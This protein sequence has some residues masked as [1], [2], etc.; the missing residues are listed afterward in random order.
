M[1]LNGR[2]SAGSRSQTAL[3]ADAF[4]CANGVTEIAE[5]S[6]V[7]EPRDGDEFVRF[8]RGAMLGTVISVLFYAAVVFAY[9]ALASIVA[10][11]AVL[12]S[13]AEHLETGV[14]ITELGS[15]SVR[16]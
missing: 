3:G 2:L 15:N 9:V 6:R 10:R 7:L 12:D 1:F 4:L 16:V 8:F 5:K 14:T 13:G 11:G